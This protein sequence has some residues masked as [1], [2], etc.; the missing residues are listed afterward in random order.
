MKT[1]LLSFLL[2][3][4]SFWVLVAFTHSNTSTTSNITINTVDTFPFLSAIKEFKGQTVVSSQGAITLSSG[5]HNDYFITDSQNKTGYLYVEAKLGAFI[6]PNTK[7]LPLNIAIVIDRSGSMAGAKMKYAKE[8]AKT[9]IDMLTP[10]DFV[11]VIIYDHEVLLIQPSINPILKDSIKKK[12]EAIEERGSTNLWGGSEKGYEQVKSSF[13]ASYVNRVLLISDGLANSGLTNS[14]IIQNK[15]RQYKDQEGITLSTFGVGLDYNEVLMTDIAES[16]SGNY[17]FINGL[18]KMSSILETE[19]NSLANIAAKD[20]TLTITIPSG[21]EIKKVYAYKADVKGNVITIKFRDLFANDTKGVL[22][23]FQ[24]QNPTFMPSTFISQ[25]SFSD[26]KDGAVKQLENK[27]LF[28]TTQLSDELMTHYN[29]SVLE[30][31]VLFQSNEALEKAMLEADRELYEGARQSL[32]RNE[33]YIN[34]HQ[35]LVQ[36]S[37]ELQKMDSANRAYYTQLQKAE[38]MNS[39]TIK[40]MQKANRAAS[41]KIRTKK[42]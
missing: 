33:A 30:Q 21:V 20:A 1:K 22:V 25:L 40:L 23:Q 12:I 19:I 5:L 28:Q 34:L 42:G 3:L 17:Y 32:K 8:A 13:K 38:Q 39:D 37:K 9:I 36:T 31:T 14:R 26:A 15:V 29:R 4:S 18:E 2:L 11:S 10:D 27:N 16:G 6:N 35:P 41:Y 24:F 7:R